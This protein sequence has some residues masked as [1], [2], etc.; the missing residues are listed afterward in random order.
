MKEGIII[1]KEQA[2][3]RLM[4]LCSEYEKCKSDL[5]QKLIHWKIPDDEASSIIERLESDNFI[6]EERYALAF[7]KDKIRFNKWGRN[8]V[9]YQLGAKRISDENI[10]I[11]LTDYDEEEYL[12]MVRKEILLKTRKV[13]ANSDWERRG[14]VMQ[15]SQTRGYESDIVMN[16]LDD[17]L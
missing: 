6:N 4:K 1:T 7:V 16:I 9:R 17:L 2:L 15:F 13:N 14:K 11:A 10:S 3:A 8:K 12:A 5:M